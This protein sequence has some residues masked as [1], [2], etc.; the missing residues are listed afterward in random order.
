VDDFGDSSAFTKT[1]PKRLGG[2]G[3]GVGLGCRGKALP[4]G[5]EGLG[6]GVLPQAPKPQTKRPPRHPSAYTPTPQPL[7]HEGEEEQHAHAT[8][9]RIASR[10]QDSVLTRFGDGCAARKAHLDC[11]CLFGAVKARPSGFPP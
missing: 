10:S 9:P 7:P 8:R 2:S 3:A 1:D 4:P 6:W 11:D 5:G